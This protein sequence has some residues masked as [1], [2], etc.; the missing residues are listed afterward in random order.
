M[1]TTAKKE[2]I[3]IR[4]D[5][6]ELEG[7]LELPENRKGIVVFAHGSGSSRFSPR[8]NYVAEVL[9]NAK[10]GTLLMDLL[11]PTEDRAFESRFN[12]SLLMQRVPAATE[13][14]Q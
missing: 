1:T 6:A 10:L 13:W 12:I 5:K 3:R 2:L 7:M 8:N 11:L 14:I 9:R 4:S